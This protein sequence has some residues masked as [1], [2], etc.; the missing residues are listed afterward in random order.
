MS[1]QIEIVTQER[2]HELADRRTG[3]ALEADEP[4]GGIGVDADRVRT[5]VHNDSP[6]EVVADAM[7]VRAPLQVV[8]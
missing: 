7:N 3:A 5:T 8:G 2:V 6:F 4:P 1:G